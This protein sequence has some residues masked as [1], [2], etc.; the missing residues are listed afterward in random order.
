MELDQ[1]RELI[2]EYLAR[3]AS[4]ANEFGSAF[5]SSNPQD[6]DLVLVEEAMMEKEFGWVFF[7]DNRKHLETG[8]FRYAI[9]PTIEGIK[10]G[11]DEVLERGI[12]VLQQMIEEAEVAGR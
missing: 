5:P 3:V 7:Y 6:L 8:D 10:A 4:D 2:E 12:E 1:A 9:G 11:R